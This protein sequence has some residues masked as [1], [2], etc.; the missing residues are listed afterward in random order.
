MNFLKI[1]NSFRYFISFFYRMLLSSYGIVLLNINE[2]KFSW[3][4]YLLAFVVYWIIFLMCFTKDSIQSKIRFLNDYALIFLIL[5]GKEYLR[6][7]NFI[8]LL[9]PILNSYNHTGQRSAIF[10]ILLYIFP[11]A[12]L[13]YSVP[14]NTTQILIP[15]LALVSINTFFALRNIVIQFNERLNQSFEK[16]YL[17]GTDIGRAHR[18]LQ[19]FVKIHAQDKLI[20]IFVN[21]NRLV[22]F[23]LVENN[24]YLI[25]SSKFIIEWELNT[26][27]EL[28]KTLNKEKNAKNIPVKI[29]DWDTTNNVIYQI[30]LN[31]NIYLFLIT[32]NKKPTTLFY[33]LYAQK[34]LFPVLKR[35]A[36]VIVTESEIRN[37]KRKLLNQIKSKLEYIDLSSNAIHFLNNKLN[38]LSLYFQLSEEIKQM[39][40]TS[41][42]YKE[43][44]EMMLASLKDA[45]DHFGIAMERIRKVMNNVN[46]PFNLSEFEEVKVQRLFVVLRAM[47][48]QFKFG[49]PAEIID[50]NWEPNDL[51]KIIKTNMP[52]FEFVFEE[53]FMNIESHGDGSLKLEFIKESENLFIIVRNN[54]KDFDNSKAIQID[55][56]IIEFN[57]ENMSEI[58]RRGIKGIR[59]LKQ[60]LQQLS[61]SHEMKRVN[62]ELILKIGVYYDKSS[63]I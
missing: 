33:D 56:Y 61:M 37:E 1:D 26:N 12:F 47:I 63:S 3:Y 45:K 28:L 2:N 6:V 34:I 54:I 58:M 4:Y 21:I 50:F 44:E 40:P 39:D 10:T 53:I 36:Q 35:I 19:N 7:D 51:D 29:D 38:P 62:N 22:C 48:L 9:L 31:Q 27:E 8:F 11:F 17:D 30:Q 32:F 46:N 43:T 20:K 5:Y 24:I 18:I 42:L 59:L 41:D 55:K 52:F 23:K 60:F 57:N 15:L 16:Y 49:N 25:N 13:L 14:F